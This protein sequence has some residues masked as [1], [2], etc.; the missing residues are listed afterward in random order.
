MR[1]GIASLWICSLLSILI[2]WGCSQSEKSAAPVGT[3][4][5]QNDVLDK[6]PL[7][8]L[9]DVLKNRSN[10][11]AYVN[12]PTELKD[13]PT[14]TVAQ[15]IIMRQKGVYGSDRRKEFFDI[16]DANAVQAA[17]SVAAIVPSSTFQQTNK[18]LQISQTTF[19]DAYHLCSDQA[20]Y[21]EPVAPG[22]TAF[23]VKDD[24]VAT[25]G[26]CVGMLASSRIVFGFRAEKQDGQV[27]YNTLI[28]ESQVYRAVQVVAQKEESA[29][30]DFALVKV[31]RPMVDHPPLKLHTNGDV[32]IGNFVYVIGYPSGLPLK[33]A[34]GAVVS[35]VAVN[36]YF[37]SNLD[38]FGG[39]SGSP[40]LNP[41]SNLVEGILVRGGTDFR[42]VGTCQ[43][44]FTCPKNP[45][46]TSDCSGEASTLMSR[47]SSALDTLNSQNT[48]SIPATMSIV[49]TFRSGE[50]LSG[51][52]ANFSS[53]YELESEPPPP[54]YKIGSFVYSLSGDRA[55][56]AWSTCSASA[57][58][59]KVVF[60]F[61]LQGHNEWPPPGQA[62]S[63]GF[64]TVT[65]AP[66]N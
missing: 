63:E 40:V 13:I 44:A 35:D 56:N 60:R 25:A 62:K 47:V 46:G 7:E 32:S 22:C 20:Y 15:H 34:D 31:D 10:K 24:I 55:C 64:L 4:K 57:D 23:V 48:K 14:G 36:G 59:N 3:V 12:E 27:H 1:R 16:Q 38:T 61:S 2:V 33:L 19:G 8:K 50:R 26:H 51:S 53:V 28:P 45:D 43:Q 39:N 18:G 37:V 21:S 52:G 29:G 41:A 5:N 42:T 11:S 17:N 65:Y 9:T 58:G 6:Y 30:V 49:K 66:A 54:G